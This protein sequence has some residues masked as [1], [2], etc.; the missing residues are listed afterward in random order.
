MMKLIAAD[1]P[2]SFVNDNQLFPR[3]ARL[4]LA[5]EICTRAGHIL[6]DK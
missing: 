1:L 6:D 2:L 4:K 3:L 5:A